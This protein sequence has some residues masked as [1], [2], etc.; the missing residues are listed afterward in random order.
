M[1]NETTW[2]MEYTNWGD[3]EP[4]NHGGEKDCTDDCHEKCIALWGEHNF[5]WN[6]AGCSEKYRIICQYPNMLDSCSEGS[7]NGS[8]FG[9]IFYNISDSKHNAEEAF[10]VCKETGGALLTIANEKVQSFISELINK[11]I[12]KLNGVVKKLF[13]TDDFWKFFLQTHLVHLQLTIVIGLCMDGGKSFVSRFLRTKM[14]QFLGR[15]SLSLYLLH[16]PL[17]GYVI[18]AINGPHSSNTIAEAWKFWRNVPFGTPAIYIIISPIICFI[19]TKYY[20]E[21]ISKMLRGTK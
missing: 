15:I 8:C 4:N 13:Q 19:A 2:D 21:P 16:L 1:N 5:K 14:M 10:A 20:E 17:M 7:Q 11:E 12:P 18:L 9:E 6:D 3:G